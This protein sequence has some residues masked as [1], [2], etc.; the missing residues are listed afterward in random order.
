MSVKKDFEE[1]LK[2]EETLNTLIKE[3]LKKVKMV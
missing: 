3:N 2:E 1:Q